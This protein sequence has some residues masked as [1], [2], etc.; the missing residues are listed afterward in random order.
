MDQAYTM[1]HAYTMDISIDGDG[2][3]TPLLGL[4]HRAINEQQILVILIVN[5]QCT[6]LACFVKHSIYSHIHSIHMLIGYF[7]KYYF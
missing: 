5:H 2:L 3:H 7:T 6:K 4:G 1:G